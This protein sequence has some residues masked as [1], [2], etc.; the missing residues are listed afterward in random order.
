MVSTRD[1]SIF[2]LILISI[3][4]IAGYS[5]NRLFF[6]S[7]VFMIANMAFYS[8]KP[9][10]LKEKAFFDVLS[11]GIIAPSLRFIAGWF[12]FT[13]SFTIPVLMIVA[14]CASQSAG[15]LLYK[16]K[17]KKIEIKTNVKTTIVFLSEK[18]LKYISRSLFSIG[19][20]SAAL[21]PI[22]SII[23]E[24]LNFLG[25]LPFRFIWAITVY[26][27]LVKIGVSR[28]HRSK[29]MFKLQ[30]FVYLSYIPASILFMLF[31]LL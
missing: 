29:G 8:L 9:F 6:Y 26:L 27:A 1:G 25:V 10:R 28:Y 21:L 13:D 3:S 15:Y 17:N 19:I 11:A 31:Y 14:V 2:A 7:M 23:F 22:N 30:T 20:L 5:I 16:F 12:L 4:L 18:S 24:N